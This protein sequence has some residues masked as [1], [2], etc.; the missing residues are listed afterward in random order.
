M[1]ERA[2]QLANQGRT[3]DVAKRS[4]AAKLS[5]RSRL[6][7]RVC[8]KIRQQTAN[9]AHG[10]G[11]SHFEGQSPHEIMSSVQLFHRVT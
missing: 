3:D 7:S 10:G 9:T 6:T 1:K 5:L 2:Q 11:D 4:K 8:L